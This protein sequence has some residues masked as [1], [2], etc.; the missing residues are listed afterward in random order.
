MKKEGTRIKEQ[1]ASNKKGRIQNSIGT[2]LYS[3][4]KK[5]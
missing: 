1:G 4:F 3:Y 2:F 5:N